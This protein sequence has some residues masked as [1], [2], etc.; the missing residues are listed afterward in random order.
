MA[1]IPNADEINRLVAVGAA[2]SLTLEFKA[3]PW[4]RND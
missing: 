2:E 1:N 3:E 4:D